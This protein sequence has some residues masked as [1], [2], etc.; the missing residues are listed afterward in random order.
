MYRKWE[1]KIIKT[2]QICLWGVQTFFT[3]HFSVGHVVDACNYFAII[4]LLFFFE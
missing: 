1:Q 3:Q 4:L 2:S